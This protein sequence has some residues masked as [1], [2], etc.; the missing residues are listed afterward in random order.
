M[1]QIF[2]NLD[3]MTKMTNTALG[4]IRRDGFALRRSTGTTLIAKLPF[5]GDGTVMRK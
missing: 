5:K 4:E 2:G 1:F 3:K